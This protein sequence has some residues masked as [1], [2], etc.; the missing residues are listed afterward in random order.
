MFAIESFVIF[1]RTI[2]VIYI[3]YMSMFPG[4]RLC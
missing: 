3:I 4:L 1:F 2:V